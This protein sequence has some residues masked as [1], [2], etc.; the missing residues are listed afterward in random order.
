MRTTIAF[1]LLASQCSAQVALQVPY[2]STDQLTCDTCSSGFVDQA[3]DALA[4][5]G[6]YGSMLEANDANARKARPLSAADSLYASTLVPVDLFEYMERVAREERIIIINESHRQPHHRVVITA[7]LEQLYDRGFRY[8]GMEAL[9]YEDTLLNSRKYPVQRSGYY[10]REPL[11]GDVVRRALE[12]GYVV[13]PYESMI[14]D[15]LPITPT[16]VSV[17]EIEQAKNIKRMLDK[18]PNAKFVIHC[19]HDHLVETPYPGWG[20]AMAGRLK[21]Y[22]G[23]DPF[24]IDQV[25][26]SE[27]SERS[28]ES[29]FYRALYADRYSFF[30]DEAGELFHGTP[31][32]ER[33]DAL[34]Y[35]PR[36]TWEHGRPDWMFMN[37][38]T[39]RSI[40]DRITVG[41][42]CLV[43]AFR[44]TELTSS[45]DPDDQPIP[46]DVVE[47]RSVNEPKPLALRSGSYTVVVRDR[48]GDLQRFELEVNTSR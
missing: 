9:G 15:T 11:A 1:L 5:I 6:E 13:F 8:F 20:M 33:C 14:F 16:S 42:P 37:G 12:I 46:F 3:A 30:A 17:R 40:I 7:L 45:D 18:D 24:T 34:L 47:I 2:R 35:H 23:I 10:T 22:T 25:P 4:L 36:T 27:R 39:P 31:G 29:G 43:M 32:K 41:Y 19:G 48:E 44:T 28:I 38:R 21:E 26:L